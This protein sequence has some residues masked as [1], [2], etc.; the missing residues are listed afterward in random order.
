[1]AGVQSIERAFSVLRALAVHPAGVTDLAERVELPKS[2]VA[3]LL[4]ALETEGA[5]EQVEPGG[6]YRL[7]QA[8]EDIAGG[9]PAGRTLAAMARPFLL[10]LTERTGETSGISVVEDGWMY[11]LEHVEVDSDIQVRDWTGEY[12][13]MHTVPSGLVFLAASGPAAIDEYLQGELTAAT[14]NTMVDPTELRERLAQITNAGYAWGYGEFAE[15]INSVAAPVFR[16]GVV[17]AALHIHGPSYRYPDPDETHDIGLLVCE[18]AAKLGAQLSE[19]R[20]VR[21]S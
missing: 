17:E 15:G 16:G 19:R 4:E 12:A 9:A 2:T 14:A 21:R 3:R 10:D 7:G 5:V 13:M 18:A 11:Y 20:L 1:M 6:E 8:I